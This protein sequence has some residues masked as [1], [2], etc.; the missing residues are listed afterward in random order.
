MF[1]VSVFILQ[2]VMSSHSMI[3]YYMFTKYL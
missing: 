3:K 2:L 1:N